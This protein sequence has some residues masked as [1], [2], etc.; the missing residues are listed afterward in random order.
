LAPGVS[1]MAICAWRPGPTCC[2][3]SAARACGCVG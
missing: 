1:C 3:G 2:E